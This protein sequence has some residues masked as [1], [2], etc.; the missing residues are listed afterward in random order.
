MLRKA[1]FLLIV[2]LLFV[3]LIKSQPSSTLKVE[4]EAGG[5]YTINSVIVIAGN[6]TNTTTGEGISANLTLN[7]L[8]NGNLIFQKNGTSD[9]N[10]LYYFILSEQFATGEYKVNITANKNGEENYCT[11]V[12][13]LFLPSKLLCE[14]KSIKVE[15]S[16]VY[17]ST[18]GPISQGNVTII[19]S[20]TG[21][22]AQASFSQ[23]HF[24]VQFS[25]CLIAGKGY[26]LVIKVEDGNG[27]YGWANLFFIA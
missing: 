8:K 24:S 26:T 19:I 17:S 7:I 13:K 9:S 11:D 25:P 2:L 5:P 15:G 20:E 4:C 12:L 6:V 1:L 27:K 14:R 21:E 16:A 22:K 10:G 18:G 23:G 3:Y